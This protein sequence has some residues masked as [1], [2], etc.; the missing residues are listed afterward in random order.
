MAL[1]TLLNLIF[2]P[3]C[4]NCNLLVPSH[5]TLC[6]S[7]WQG[8]E[9]ITDP[10]CQC[11]G[12]PFAFATGEQSLCGECLQSP[13]PYARARAAFRYSDASRDL[14]R[15]LKFHDQTLLARIF[16]T[17]LI[18][19]G[20]PLIDDCELIVPVPLHY[21]RFV[22]RRYNQSALLAQ[23]LSRQ[24]GLPV[25]VDGLSRTRNTPPQSSLTRKQ[26]IE[27][28]RDVFTVTPRHARAIRGRRVLLVDDVIT[29]AATV[30]ECTQ[31]LLAAGAAS[32]QVLALA[33][34][35]H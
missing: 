34:T 10:C 13:P 23:S 4:L 3:Q 26:R 5:G 6:L 8:I 1:A 27:N 16:A 21:W 12:Y 28:V 20:R 11:C 14:V 15:K 9:F 24:C 17:W 35:V 7:C 30:R 2:P 32:V 19:A 31:A 33:R 22:R 29:T 25:L 18:S